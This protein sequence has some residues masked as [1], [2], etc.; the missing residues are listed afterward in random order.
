MH[1]IYTN[2]NAPHTISF[3]LINECY[4]NWGKPER[5]PLLHGKWCG[6]P[7]VKNSDEKRDCNTL[8]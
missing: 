3:T 7:C 5:A 6:C 1:H 8:P 2:S 4:N